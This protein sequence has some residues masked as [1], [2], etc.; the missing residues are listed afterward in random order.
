MPRLVALLRHTSP[1]VQTPALRCV[2]NVAA[3]TADE[4][5]A[6]LACD[7]LGAVGLLLESGKKEIKKEACWMV[8]RRHPRAWR[9][10][11]GITW[12][13]AAARASSER[14]RLTSSM[15][16]MAGM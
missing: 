12:Q 11:A 2:G 6:M 5:Q 9:V 15:P 13:R 4:T 1:N 14:R 7:A 3:G 8:R 16:A 10:A